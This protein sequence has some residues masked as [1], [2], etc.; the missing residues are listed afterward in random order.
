MICGQKVNKKI[1][2]D[3]AMTQN[4]KE[5]TLKELEEWL[6]KEQ[7]ERLFLEHYLTLVGKDNQKVKLAD[8]LNLDDIME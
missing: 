2:K 4:H 6:G 7:V 1:R 5:M 8:H 3:K